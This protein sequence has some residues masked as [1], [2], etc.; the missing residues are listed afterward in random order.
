[1]PNWCNNTVEINHTDK[2]KMYELVGA[3]NEGRFCDHVMPVPESL[4]IV[5]GMVSDE[6]EQKKL[7]EDTARNLEVHGYGN[8]YDYCVNNWGTKWDVE[9]YDTV[10]YDDQHAKHGITFGFDSAWAPPLGIYE[11]LVEQ[12]FTVRGYYY[13][14]GM[15]FAGIWEDGCDDFYELNEMTSTELADTLPSVLDDM[16]CISENAAEWEAENAEE[17]EVQEWYEEGVEK[18][19]LTPHKS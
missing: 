13:E 6:A 12:G 10:D 11:A 15:C 19:G 14:P 9:A 5:A 16:F 18:K 7:E 3:I 1:M 8:W 4:K 17:D 2:S